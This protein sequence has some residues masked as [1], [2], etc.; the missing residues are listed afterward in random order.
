MIIIATMILPSDPIKLNGNIYPNYAVSIGW[1][2]VAIPISAIPICAL[3]QFLLQYRGEKNYVTL[4]M[5]FT[6]KYSNLFNSLQRKLFEP[7][8]E[9]YE[10]K[11]KFFK[12]Q[13]NKL[14][15]SKPRDTMFLSN[16]RKNG[17]IAIKF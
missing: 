15:E 13:G 4:F 12:K 3:Y 2:I 17:N 6:F 16:L 10:T 8:F 1:V 11:E 7:C 9:F 5:Q 14:T